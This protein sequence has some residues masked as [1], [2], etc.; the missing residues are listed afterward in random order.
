VVRNEGERLRKVIV[1]TP[2]NEY[3]T[4]DDPHAHNITQSAH[5]ERA[6]EQHGRLCGVMQ[7]AGVDVINIPELENHPN[8]VF[9]RDTCVCCPE[10]FIQLRMGLA[11]RQGEGAWMARHLEEMSIKKYG[12][13]L[14]P[15]T[16]EGGDIILAGGVVFIGRSMRSNNEGIGQAKALFEKIGYEVRIV[17][18]PQ[19]RLH[20]GGMMSMVGPRRIVYCEELFP[21]DFF[22]GFETIRVPAGHFISGNVICLSRNVVIAEKSN[23][24]TISALEGA[25]IHVVAIDLSEFIKGRGGPTCLILPMERVGE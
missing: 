23:T 8:S 20:I 14:E 15:G 6:V 4:I 25:G 19:P 24:V 10:G 18:V 21:D 12:Q 22:F 13:V 3:Y 7:G 1:C 16:I 9:T 2:V 17:H 11:S 5:K